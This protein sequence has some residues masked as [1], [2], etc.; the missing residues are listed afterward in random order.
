M[1]KAYA[2]LL[3]ALKS[4]PPGFT[5]IYAISDATAIGALRACHDAKVKVPEDLSVIAMDNI[6]E[7]EFC[8]P[9]LTTFKHDMQAWANSI[10]EIFKRRLE[11]EKGAPIQKAHVPI[12]IP[13][14]STGKPK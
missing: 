3:S 4:G 12:L 1:R 6:Q 2:A 5:G 10:V 11:G 7:G 9:S 13:R 8:V 14:E